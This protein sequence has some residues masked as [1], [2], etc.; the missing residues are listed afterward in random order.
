M[1]DNVQFIWS[2]TKFLACILCILSSAIWWLI[3]FAILGYVAIVLGPLFA[4]LTYATEIS[5]ALK[6]ENSENE[7]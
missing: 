4:V 3:G 1:K 2:C 7:D 5:P 6:K